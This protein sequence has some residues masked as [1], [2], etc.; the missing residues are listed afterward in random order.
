MQSVENKG[1]HKQISDV[2]D[3]LLSRM[4]INEITLDKIDKLK[5]EEIN[6]AGS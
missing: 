4:K 5:K 3:T 6:Y 1:Q 2:S